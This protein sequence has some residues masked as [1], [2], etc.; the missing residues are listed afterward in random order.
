MAESILDLKDDEW[1]DWETKA[2]HVPFWKH[3]VAGNHFA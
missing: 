1:L 3:A 2:D